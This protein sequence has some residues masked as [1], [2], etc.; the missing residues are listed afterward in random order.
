MFMFNG[1]E[2]AAQQSLAKAT[3]L[4]REQRQYVGAL[5][6]QIVKKRRAKQGA[7]D[8]KWAA[9]ETADAAR[10]KFN[11]DEQRKRRAATDKALGIKSQLDRQRADNQARAAKE[12]ARESADAHRWAARFDDETK[13]EARKKLAEKARKKSMAVRQM[14]DVR[15]QIKERERR[16]GA[17]RQEMMRMARMMHEA[18]QRKDDQRKA[19]LQSKMDENKRRLEKANGGWAGEVKANEAAAEAAVES[20]A[21]KQLRAK[22]AEAKRKVDMRKQA[23][24]DNKEW[25]RLRLEAKEARRQQALVERERYRQ[26]LVG[27]AKDYQSDKV[28]ERGGARGARGARWSEVERVDR[29]GALE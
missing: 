18:Q 14:E 17:E 24:R 4:E 23:N 22:D 8:Q 6:K 25:L 11:A 13:V 1:P 7:L 27:V 19:L 21:E 20:A 26:E 29:G 5:Q 9:R 12:K 15:L 2:L 16:E 28:S 3:K 10:L